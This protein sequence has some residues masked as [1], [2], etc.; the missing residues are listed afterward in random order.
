VSSTTPEIVVAGTDGGAL[1]ELDEYEKVGGL[2]ALRRARAMTPDEIVAELNASNLRGRGGAFFPTG[3]KWSFIPKPDQNPRPHYL[4]VNADE[5]EPGTFKDREIMLRVPFRFLEGCLIAARAIE[6]THVFV[7]IRG[8]Y[9][10]EWE[11]LV[12]ALEQLR[13]AKH[14]GDVTLVLHRGAGAYICGEET[15]LLESLEGYRGQPRTKPPFPAIAGLYA[16]PTA[17]NNVESITT[18]PPIIE[19]GGAEYATL[20]VQDSAGTRVFSLSGNVERPGNYELPHGFPLKDLIYEVGGGIADGRTLKAVIPGGSSTPILTAAEA[21][22]VTLDFDSLSQAGTAI[23]S[24]AVIVLDDRC[25]MVQLGVRVSQFYEHESCGKCTPCR[26]GTRWLT[27]ILKKIES[28][29]GTHA[30]LDLL[31]DV[32]ERINGTCLCPLGDSDAI[33]VASY[34]AKFREEFLQHVEEAGCP[35]HGTSSLDGIVAP[36][37][38]HEAHVGP[39]EIRRPLEVVA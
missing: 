2:Q 16:S 14:L 29:D 11:I 35:F 24:A 21:E 12:S 13:A 4:V 18:V 38:V 25:C 9:E 39:A 22:K 34:V 10:R 20:G 19:M 31:L 5:S 32:G 23:G 36:T 28:G 27:Q 6:S 1:T 7:Y 17:V 37:D 8:E 26:V 33:A 15:A 3:R 30:D